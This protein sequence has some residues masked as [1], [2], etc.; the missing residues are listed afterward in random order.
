LRSVCLCLRFSNSFC[1][2][3]VSSLICLHALYSIRNQRTCLVLAKHSISSTKENAFTLLIKSSTKLL[4][5]L[6][7]A[8]L[9]SF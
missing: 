5:K 2:S 6:S 7:H 8:P 9:N 3:T 4:L 1:F